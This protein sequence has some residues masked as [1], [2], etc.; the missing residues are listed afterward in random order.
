MIPP[1]HEAGVE[2]SET[3]SSTVVAAD[4]QY[5]T[6]FDSIPKDQQLSA[7]ADDF[8][9]AFDS[10]NADE[11]L[12]EKYSVQPVDVLHNSLL[13]FSGEDSEMIG[14]ADITLQELGSAEQ[15]PDEVPETNYMLVQLEAEGA[16]PEETIFLENGVTAVRT[17]HGDIV[18][19]SASDDEL[20]PQMNNISELPVSN[21]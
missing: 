21:V 18:L 3:A 17:Y 5:N 11:N 13:N 4:D 12:D 10:Y 20:L 19:S 16:I 7:Y 14:L 9:R 15:L 6:L 8:Y 1:I 2:L